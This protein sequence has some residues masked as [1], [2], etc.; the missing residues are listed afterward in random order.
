MK[1]ALGWLGIVTMGT[2][3]L[4]GTSG[5]EVACAEDEEKKGTTCVAKSLTRYSG[6]DGTDDAVWTSGGD[7]T[8]DGVFGHI[9]VNVGTHTGK[10]NVV[11]KPFSY[12]AHDD[13]GEAAAI[14]DM[15]EALKSDASENG[16]GV[17]VKTW[18]EGTHGSSLGAQIEVTLPSDF[19]GKLIVNNH[20][21]GN[22]STQDEFDVDISGV[23]SAP[24][25]DVRAESDLGE[26]N[27][28]AASSV[29]SSEVHCGDF[30]GLFDVSDTVNASTSDSNVLD[31]AINIRFASITGGSGGTIRSEDGTISLEFPAGAVFSVQAQS[32]ADGMVNV[33]GQPAEC[34]IQEAAAT[35]KTLTCGS[36]GPNYVVTAGAGTLGD[37]DVHLNF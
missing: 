32:A 2:F 22:V 3:F 5:C 21:D 28:Q 8:V 11:F 7:V 12:R 13:E 14:R 19:N 4:A 16:S 9:T 37:G 36:G 17:L 34:S 20:G 24:A 6:Q 33:A 27:I 35:S 26:C 25:I 10:V 15:E 18:R 30:V 29:T 23:A 31:D 1:T